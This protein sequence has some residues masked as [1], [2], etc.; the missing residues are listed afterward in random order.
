MIECQ[1]NFSSLFL[2]VSPMDLQ[3]DVTLTLNQMEAI[4]YEDWVR[5]VSRDPFVI[6]EKEI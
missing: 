6:G 2:Y 1:L 5:Q 4:D 3:L